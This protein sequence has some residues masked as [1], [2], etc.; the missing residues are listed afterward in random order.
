MKDTIPTKIVREIIADILIRRSN[1]IMQA[2]DELSEKSIQETGICDEYALEVGVESCGTRVLADDIISGNIS[3]KE[4]ISEIL[5]Q[6]EIREAKTRCLNYIA[7]KQKSEK[8]R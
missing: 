1:A 6:D 2:C 8:E 4:A 7:E 3:I 5:T